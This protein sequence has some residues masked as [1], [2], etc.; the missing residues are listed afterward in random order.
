[1]S[2]VD[3][4]GGGGGAGLRL[5]ALP[6]RRV[7]KRHGWLC[8]GQRRKVG[9]WRM[10]FAEVNAESWKRHKSSLPRKVVGK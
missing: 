3:L 4:G 9:D 8:R 6:G 10:G 1:M 5:S 2:W 7:K